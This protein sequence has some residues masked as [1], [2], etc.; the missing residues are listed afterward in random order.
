MFFFFSNLK[1]SQ[2]KIKANQTAIDQIQKKRADLNARLEKLE[3]L[4]K[5]ADEKKTQTEVHSNRII[6]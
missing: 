1:K 6:T 5:N 3:E 4:A 2:D